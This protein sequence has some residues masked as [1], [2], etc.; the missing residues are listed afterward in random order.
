MAAP[1][2]EAVCLAIC[3]WRRAIC[4]WR[5]VKA[6]GDGGHPGTGVPTARN[7][8]V[9]AILIHGVSHTTIIHYP[10][11]ILKRGG[12]IENAALPKAVCVILRAAIGGP[13]N[14]FPWGLRIAPQGHFLGL[15][16]Q[17]ATV[18]SLLRNDSASMGITD[19]R[20]RVPLQLAM[21]AHSRGRRP[22][23]PADTVHRKGPRS[24]EKP[25]ISQTPFLCFCIVHKGGGF[26]LLILSKIDKMYCNFSQ[27]L[28]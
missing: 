7:D 5:R 22:R 12:R 28:I 16:P 25:V 15:R 17:G 26:F 2:Y 24:P 19:T 14:P 27:S 13:K 10:F 23:R 8:R 9:G 11:S 3:A 18:A 6:K 21:T 1:R 20:G 4:A